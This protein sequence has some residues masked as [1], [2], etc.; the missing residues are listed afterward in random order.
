MSGD[1][2]V[3]VVSRSYNMIQKSRIIL[4]FCIYSS[5][6]ARIVHIHI[7]I[8]PYDKERSEIK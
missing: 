1:I 3:N 6:V 7:H 8:F 2:N 4:N 5:P